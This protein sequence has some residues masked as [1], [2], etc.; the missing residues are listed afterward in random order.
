MVGSTALTNNR[1]KWIASY[2][3]HFTKQ[4]FINWTKAKAALTKKIWPKVCI[5]IWTSVRKDFYG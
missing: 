2:R 4:E 1:Y 3:I 5:W